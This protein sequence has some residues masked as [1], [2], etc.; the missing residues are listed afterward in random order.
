VKENSE[1]GPK[2]TYPVIS[3]YNPG[4]SDA[5]HCNNMKLLM[6]GDAVQVLV[7][8]TMDYMTKKQVKLKNTIALISKRVKYYD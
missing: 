3:V 8:Y 6:S 1:W 4:V 5:A 7:F 2:C